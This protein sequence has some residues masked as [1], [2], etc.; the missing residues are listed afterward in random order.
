MKMAD[1]ELLE[2]IQQEVE[3]VVERLVDNGTS[4]RACAYALISFGIGILEGDGMDPDAINAFLSTYVD[5]VI[6]KRR[7]DMKS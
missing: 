3:P 7:K 1:V 5:K 6:R 4:S 2:T